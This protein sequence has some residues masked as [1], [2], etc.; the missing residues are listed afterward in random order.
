MLEHLRRVYPKQ[1]KELLAVAQVLKRC[2][3]NML[4]TESLPHWLPPYP[5]PNL[6]RDCAEHEVFLLKEG[7]TGIHT[8]QLR[9]PHPGEAALHK[10]ATLPERAGQGIGQQSLDWIECYIQKQD[11]TRL[12]LEVYEQS[13]RA[14]TFYLR[15][16][17]S[18]TGTRQTSRFQV[19]CLQK[20]L[21]NAVWQVPDV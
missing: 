10:F 8:F 14:L 20:E 5:L 17:F 18:V 9:Y 2:G 1:E 21:P 12:C 13:E 7:E 3:E 16:G 6:R 19:L 11:I 4:Q 15:S